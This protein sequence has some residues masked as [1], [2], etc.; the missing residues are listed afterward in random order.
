[1]TTPRTPG[2]RIMRVPAVEHATGYSRPTIYRLERQGKFPPRVKIGEGQ[3]GAVG[4]LAADVDAWIS[5]RIAGK[6]WTP[7]AAG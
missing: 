1:M 3:G 5:A 7:P 4:W 2:Q 6:P